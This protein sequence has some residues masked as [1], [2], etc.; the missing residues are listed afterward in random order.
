MQN[1]DNISTILKRKI[2]NQVISHGLAPQARLKIVAARSHLREVGQCQTSF[3]NT[4]KKPVR[5]VGA[6]LRDISSGS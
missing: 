1:A 6:V 3:L 2:E 5:V 4:I